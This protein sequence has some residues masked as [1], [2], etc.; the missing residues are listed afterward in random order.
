MRLRKLLKREWVVKTYASRNW[1]EVFYGEVKGWLGW[2][3]YQV[4]FIRSIRRHLILVFVAYTFVQWH[5]LTGGRP[6]T[7][8][9]KEAENLG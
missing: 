4:R 1:I 2:K 3:E 7:V 5:Q 6:L 9:E 8:G